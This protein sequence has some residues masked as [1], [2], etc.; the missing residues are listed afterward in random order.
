MLLN[1]LPYDP[2]TRAP[3]HPSV[4]DHAWLTA[5]QNDRFSGA[6]DSVLRLHPTLVTLLSLATDPSGRHARD[7]ASP[8]CK[9]LFLQTLYFL[10]RYEFTTPVDAPHHH[11]LT[12]VVHLA[13]DHGDHD[14]QVALKFLSQREHFDKEVR[15][16]Q[17][18]KFSDEFVVGVIRTHEED[19]DETF[20]NEAK[21]KGLEGAKFCLVMEAGERT[22]HDVLFKVSEC[23]RVGE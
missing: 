8:I 3:I 21:R 9:Q 11:S 7:L 20:A 1:S 17:V 12:C 6:V 14:R 16:R 2:A 19:R 15:S 22:L 5:V 18:G 23:V 10:R 13:I 4:H